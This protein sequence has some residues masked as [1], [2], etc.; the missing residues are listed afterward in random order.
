MRTAT[1]TWV[2]YRN[3][4]TLLQAYALQKKI[5]QLGHENMILDDY[6]IMLAINKKKSFEKI[7][8]TNST[9]RNVGLFGRA[10]N[11]MRHPKKIKRIIASRF[12]RRK[13]EQPFMESL[14]LFYN[15]KKQKRYFFILIS[16]PISVSIHPLK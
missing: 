16:F 10:I 15:F 7:Q 8:N 12:D 14:E 5:Q 4:G 11:I 9:T 13:Y 3:Y 2:N 6:E 1:V